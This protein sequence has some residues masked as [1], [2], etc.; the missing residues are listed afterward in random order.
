MSDAYRDD[1]EAA[2]LRLQDLEREHATLEARNAELQ[3]QL[4]RSEPPPAT[5]KPVAVTPAP[6]FY[7]TATLAILGIVAL[8]LTP[9]TADAAGMVAVLLVCGAI[10]IPLGLGGV[11]R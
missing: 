6:I 9:S 3:T 8:S 4:K 7:L 1:G 2:Q 10:A 5:A 11:R